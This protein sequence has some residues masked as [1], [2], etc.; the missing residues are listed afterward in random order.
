MFNKNNFFHYFLAII[1]F[2]SHNTLWANDDIAKKYGCKNLHEIQ[3]GEDALQQLYDNLNTDCFDKISDIEL[4]K[5]W[6]IIVYDIAKTNKMSEKE[7]SNYTYNKPILK[8]KMEKK[9][10]AEFKDKNIAQLKLKISAKHDKYR[11]NTSTDNIGIFPYADKFPEN[12]SQPT[13]SCKATR[14]TW[15]MIG[16][17]GFNLT[18]YGIYSP[19]CEYFWESNNK[20]KKLKLL[21]SYPDEQHFYFPNGSISAFYFFI[22]TD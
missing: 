7:F 2:V 19:K 21:I 12:L 13:I 15:Q 3:S 1:F 22:N 20:K 8:G 5:I 14:R 16:T 6:G 4:E 10:I 11:L 9:L 18:N 17:L